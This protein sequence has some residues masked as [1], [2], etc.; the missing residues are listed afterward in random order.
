MRKAYERAA[1]S[2]SATSYL[3][4][5]GTGTPVGDP[6]EVAAVGR[7]FSSCRDAR[8]PLLIGSVIHSSS[9]HFFDLTGE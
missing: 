3:E 8:D 7:V 2:F 9:R 6:L 4:C 1:I 5:H